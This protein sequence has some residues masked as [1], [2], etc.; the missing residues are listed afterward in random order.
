MEGNGYLKIRKCESP[1]QFC[2][3]VEMEKK[4]TTQ[5]KSQMF[6]LDVEDD[7]ASQDC[8]S[9]SKTFNMEMII[10]FSGASR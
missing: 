4:R 6:S 10:E 2:L 7:A 5:E 1:L 9:H 3:L 8:S